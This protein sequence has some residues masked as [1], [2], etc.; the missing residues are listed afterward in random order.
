M[1]PTPKLGYKLRGACLLMWM[2][3]VCERREG[4]KREDEDED[5]KSVKV[6]NN[7][8]GELFI[9]YSNDQ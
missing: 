8:V 1:A 9:D 4:E 5:M 2:V 6:F 3:A 7:T